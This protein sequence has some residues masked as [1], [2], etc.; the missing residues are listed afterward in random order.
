MKHRACVI[1]GVSFLPAL[2]DAFYC[3]PRCRQEAQRAGKALFPEAAHVGERGTAQSTIEMQDATLAPRIEVEAHAV[4]ELDRRQIDSTIEEAAECGRT[5]APLSAIGGQRNAC[6]VLAGERQREA[7]TLA[8]LKAEHA[9]LVAEGR[10][11]ESEAAP[12]HGAQPIGADKDSEWAIRWFLALMM[13]CC[14]PP[15]RAPTAAASARNRPQSDAALPK[16]MDDVLQ[17]AD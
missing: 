4:A 15:A 13:L 11:I 2:R 8:N 6:Q 1:C 14:D 10:Q 17:I 9:T 5:D 3:S 16:I 12:N 7:A